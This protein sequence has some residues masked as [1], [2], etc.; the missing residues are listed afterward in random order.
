MNLAWFSQ[1]EQKTMSAVLNRQI[2]AFSPDSDSDILRETLAG[3][4]YRAKITEIGA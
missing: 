4:M 1:G 2:V 3:C